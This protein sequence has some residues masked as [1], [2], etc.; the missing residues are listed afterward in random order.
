[1]TVSPTTLLRI[2]FSKLVIPDPPKDP[3]C[4]PLPSTCVIAM[5]PAPFDSVSPVPSTNL[6]VCL[7]FSDGT[8][9]LMLS[10]HTPG[11]RIKTGCVV[12]PTHEPNS[13]HV[14]GGEYRTDF[15]ETLSIKLCTRSMLSVRGDPRRSLSCRTSLIHPFAGCTVVHYAYLHFQ[16]LDRHMRPPRLY[17]GSTG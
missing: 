6:D 5:S 8:S 4:S 7:Q 11:R 3:G 9:P 1:M 12:S 17:S 2:F 16:A 15:S 14:P 10:Q 13:S